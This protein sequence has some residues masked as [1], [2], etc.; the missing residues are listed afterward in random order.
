MMNRN[1]FGG[2]ILAVSL[3][4]FST[5]CVRAQIIADRVYGQPDFATALPGNS[6]VPPNARINLPYDVAAGPEGV[7]ISD[8]YYH[9]VLFF[10]GEAVEATAVYGQPNFE[11]LSPN[12]GGVSANSLNYPWGVARD[13]FG[14]YIADGNNNRVLFYPHGSTTA[15]RVYG[16]PSF[17]SNKANYYG[18]N[19]NSLFGPSFLATDGTGGLY[20]AD[21]G[22][23]RVL[24]FP[25]NSTTATKVWGQ[26]KFTTNYQGASDTAVSSPRGIAVDSEGLYVVDYNNHR[27]LFFPHGSTTATRV[28]GQPDFTSFFPND[29][30]CGPNTLQQPLGCAVDET[31]F[32]VDDYLNSRALFWPHGSNVASVVYGQTDFTTVRLNWNGVTPYGFYAPRSVTTDATGVYVCDF[33]GRVLRFPKTTTP[34][35]ASVSFLTAPVGARAG[36]PFEVQPSAVVRY[37]NGAQATNYTG[38]VRIRIKPGSGPSCGTLLGTTTVSAVAGIATFTNLAIDKPGTYEL[39]VTTA[40]LPIP[41]TVS[42][43]IG[44]APGES[45]AGDVNGDGFFN[46]A[47]VAATLKIAA[48]L[49]TP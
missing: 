18:L 35:A 36:Q 33:G 43:T 4:V 3:M 13:S 39:M 10:P 5:A 32:Y 19:E 38:N 49:S 15:T 30:G 7:Y 44:A 14:V 24:Y 20:V 48:G 47:D 8:N 9:R 12:N 31:G 45:L 16:Q 22:N 1:L 25:P 21:T 6:A 34:M 26:P 23:N 46:V 29:G 37:S 41:E 28:Y 11:S 27:A 17:T 40:T 2:L 42:V